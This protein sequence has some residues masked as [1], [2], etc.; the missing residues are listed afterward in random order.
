MKRTVTFKDQRIFS[1]EELTKILIPDLDCS[2]C[3]VRIYIQSSAKQEL[4]IEV[5]KEDKD[6]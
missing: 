2:D 6:E 5:I 3:D 4:C 1:I